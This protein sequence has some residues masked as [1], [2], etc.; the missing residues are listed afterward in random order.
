MP[1][2]QLTIG[3]L[4][5]RTGVATSALRY[6]EAL[7]LLPPP[8]R[9][10][11]RRRYPPSTVALVGEIL[12]LRDVGFTLRELK[13]FTAARSQAGDGWRQLHQRKLTELDQRIAQAQAAR[14]A[15]AHALAC[16]HDDIR[17]CP[18]LRQRGRGTPGRIIPQAGPP[19]LT[20][21]HNARDATRPLALIGITCS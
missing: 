12:L 13:T 7:G 4:A 21:R 11:G 5:R 20:L 6:W 15:I 3:E 19:S 14:T 16:P 10:S 8:A 9:V 18:H 1:Q 17:A 2:E